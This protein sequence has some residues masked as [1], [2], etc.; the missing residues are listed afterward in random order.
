M[1]L[2]IIMICVVLE[3]IAPTLGN[4]YLGVYDR[5]SPYECGFDPAGVGHVNFSVRYFLVAIIFLIFDVE[6][7]LLLPLAI[8]P[9]GRVYMIWGSAIRVFLLVLTLGTFY[10]WKEG[11]LDWRY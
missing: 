11:A 4:K 1:G 9:S 3:L 7:A 8:T 2:L 5:S 6:V 10:E